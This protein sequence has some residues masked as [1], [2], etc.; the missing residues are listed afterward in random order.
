MSDKH[1]DDR[2]IEEPDREGSNKSDRV[3]PFAALLGMHAGISAD[4]VGTVSMPIHNHHLQ[5]S[6]NVQGGLI[7]TLV[8]YAFYLA[9]RSRLSPGQTTVTVELKVNF[10]AGANDGELTA[11]A[12]VVSG[13]RRIFVVEGDV[14]DSN[15]VVIARGLSTYIVSQPRV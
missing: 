7:V 6:G 5:D 4:G 3:P 12:R 14:S 2:V 8:D 9:V 15:G 11:T 10:I 13:G 1:H